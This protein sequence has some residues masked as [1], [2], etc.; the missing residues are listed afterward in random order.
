ML[1]DQCTTAAV[2]RAH[3]LGINTIL[4]EHCDS[5]S[6]Q[7]QLAMIQKRSLAVLPIDNRTVRG[8]GLVGWTFPD[9]P[10]NNRWTPATLRKAHSFVRGRDRKSTRLNSSHSS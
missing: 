9:E 10:E 4:N 5:L 7:R 6:A 3:K 8:S 1:I 2:A